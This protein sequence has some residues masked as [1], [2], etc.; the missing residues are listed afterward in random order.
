M[1]GISVI[2]RKE[3]SDAMSNKAFLLSLA[4]LMLN[5][6]LTGAT[7]SGTYTSYFENEKARGNDTTTCCLIII[8]TLIP[9]IKVLGALV[10]IAYGFNAINKERTEGNLKVLLSYPIYIKPD[11]LLRF[12][13]FTALS[14]LFLS[15]YLGLSMLLSI[16]SKDQK[17]TLLGMLLIIGV[18]NSYAFISDS[19][20]YVLYVWC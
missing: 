9:H 1:A 16:A 15:G 19:P 20:R 6:T 3:V 5:M 7:S 4:V 12:T 13:I 14:A 11:P 10:A 2:V 18:F 8:D 17:T